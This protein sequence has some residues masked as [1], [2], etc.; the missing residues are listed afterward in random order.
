MNM[1]FDI[2]I[3]GGAAGAPGSYLG[4]NNFGNACDGRRASV[5]AVPGLEEYY[6]KNIFL[7][8]ALT[9]EAIKALD[10]VKQ[11]DKPFFLYM[12]HY[13]IHGPIEKDMRFYEKYKKKGLSDTDA[14]Y[15]ALLEGM[16]KS[17]L[18]N[19]CP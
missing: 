4:M 13:A 15:A 12:S 2:N 14:G 18:Q 19:L 3:N 16:D 11:E 17:F 1:G 10:K 7:T 6:G 9:L 8:E 5:F